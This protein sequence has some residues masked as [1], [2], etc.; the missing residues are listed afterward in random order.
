MA[1]AQTSGDEGAASFATG[2]PNLDLLLGGGVPAA[3][4]MLV[5][6]VGLR[7]TPRELVAKAA[8]LGIDLEGAIRKERVV[9]VHHSPIEL[10]ADEL[11]WKVIEALERLGPARM[12]IDGI[13]DL[14]RSLPAERAWGWIA[15]LIRRL[16]GLGVTSLV[17]KEVAQV[18]G[19]ELDFSD[20]PLAVLAESSMLFRYVE[21]EGRLI[22]I[23]SVLKMADGECDVSIRQ[24]TITDGGLRVLGPAQSAA[25][26][27]T[28]IARLGSERRIKRSKPGARAG[29]RGR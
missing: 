22:R 26:L 29:A 5:L 17:L 25:G 12:V 19:P 20:T 16:H 15:S 2:I 24:Y 14:E 11:G 10:V 1:E 13:A 9:L 8:R 4:V 23:L 21:L 18:V 7:E 27:L 6:C 28:G 3:D